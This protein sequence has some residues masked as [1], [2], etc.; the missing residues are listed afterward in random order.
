MNTASAKLLS[1]ILR[2]SVLFLLLPVSFPAFA[3]EGLPY[4]EVFTD[5]SAIM[6]L[7]EPD[8]GSIIDANVAAQEFYGYSADEL[9]TMKIQNIN[10]FTPEQVRAERQ[11]AKTENRNFF[12]FRHR[13]AN[14]ETRTVE[15]HSTPLIYAG[16]AA[17]LS[18]VHDISEDREREAELQH[19]RFRLEEM[20]DQK[21]AELSSAYRA[22]NRWMMALVTTLAVSLAVVCYLLY[23]RNA[24]HRRLSVSE[25]RFRET[26]LATNAGIWEWDLP[27]GEVIINERWAE[28]IGY[29]MEELVPV[30]IS[31]WNGLVHP[32]DLAVSD[33]KLS[34]LLAGKRDY[35]DCEVRMRHK[36]GHWIWVLDRGNI[37]DWT[38]DGKP[39][40]I[41]GTHADITRLKLTEEKAR[42]L[43]MT[44]HLTGLSNRAH[45]SEC[46]EDS[47]R[48]AS[49]E[50][51]RFALLALDLDKFKTVNDD[52]GHPVGDALLQSVAASIRKCVRE[53]DVVTR[54]GGDEFAVII[55]D[56]A[57]EKDVLKCADRIHEEISKPIMA[58][59]KTLAVGI[60]IGVA[61]F[62]KDAGSAEDLIRKADQAMYEAKKG[63]LRTL[64]FDRSIMRATG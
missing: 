18:I 32:D 49:R 61:H 28:I 44:D 57:D 37:V 64:T 58:M 33:R 39:T 55:G 22:S 56:Y 5:H 38:R 40:R 27:G 21:T 11:L 15:V 43:A 31:T 36:E 17:L 46:L 23:L 30:T 10:R 62:P 20:V 29:S 59:G 53:S 7:I 42:R 6:L 35:Y 47:I 41:S 45:F 52:H 54:I 60:S 13:L 24:D 63:N 16:A 3:E 8:S 26:L 50:G 19:Y 48:V 51:R 1:S 2:I 4:S 9:R 34:E 25:R 12:I 14:G